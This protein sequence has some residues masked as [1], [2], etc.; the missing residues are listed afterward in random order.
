MEEMHARLKQVRVTLGLTQKAM[1]EAL[2][3]SGSAYHYV[4]KGQ[5]KITN[6]LVKILVLSHKI[7][8]KWLLTGQ[9]WFNPLIL[10]RFF[11]SKKND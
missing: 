2:S 8:E 10:A 11:R 6:R 3:M 9:G 7:N 4:E 5:N 1:A